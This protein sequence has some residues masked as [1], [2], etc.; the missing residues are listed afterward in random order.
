MARD[1]WT[2]TQLNTPAQQVYQGYLTTISQAWSGSLTAVQRAAW[3]AAALGVRY[4]NRLGNSYQPTGYLHYLR[5][6]LVRFTINPTLMADPPVGE[7]GASPGRWR[8][9]QGVGDTYIT[10][11][12]GDFG[13]GQLPDVVQI[14]KAGPFDGGGYRAR[15]QEFRLITNQT[16]PYEYH[17]ASYIAGKWYWYI[18]RWAYETGFKGNEF[19][20]QLQ[21]A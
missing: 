13:L 21:A 11:D 10:I 15:R 5:L 7:F 16:F 4:I 3:E 18:A 12:M 2:G 17:D 6:N 20:A 9:F 14:F 19:Y 8:V 1:V